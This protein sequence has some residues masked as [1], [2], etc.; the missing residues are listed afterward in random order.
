[1]AEVGNGPPALAGEYRTVARAAL[2]G[3]VGEVARWVPSVAGG[4]N[5]ALIEAAYAV[6]LSPVHPRSEA[7]AGFM[8]NGIA[9]ETQQPTLCLVITSVGVYGLMQALY[10]ASVNRRPLVVVSGE[11]SA[12][13]RGSVQAGDGWDGPSVTVAT[14]PF[15][16]WS[17]DAS[18]ADLAIRGL[19]RAVRIAREKRLPVHVNIP[20]KVQK[21]LSR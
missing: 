2:A 4:N 9:W 14:R 10:A 20:L 3:I 18:S 13:G 11:V 1:M 6:G 5:M 19:R 7:G 21:E 16:A 15:T 17:I 12:I 8:A